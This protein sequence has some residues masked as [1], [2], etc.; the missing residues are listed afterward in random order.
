VSADHG[1]VDLL[2]PTEEEIRRHV[3]VELHARALAELVRPA[4]ASASDVRPTIEGHGDYVFGMLLGPVFVPGEDRKY[5]QEVDFVLTPDRLLTVR[6]TP[7][8]D[9]PFDPSEIHRVCA[10]RRHIK[11]GMIAYHFADAVAEQFL[12]L[13]D[14]LEDELEDV[15]SGL[16]TRPAPEVQRQFI[17]LRQH[18]IGIRRTLGPTR[19][20]MRSVV[21]GR[22][23]IEGKPVFRR[24]VFPLDVELHFAQVYDK[25]L[26]A[27][28]GLD[29]ARD[30]IT[31][32]RDFH[33]SLAANEQNRIGRMLTVIASLLLFPT[34]IVGVYGQ[35]F[36]H[37]PE[38]GWRYGYLFSWGVIV[39]VTLI[40]L[41]LFRWRRWI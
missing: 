17:E 23:D 31:S 12:D 1:W 26:R 18:V 28:E 6:K 4:A 38:L 20:A 36:H 14:V 19:D 39:A 40:Q 37:M 27:S 41:A 16:E 2:D 30:L 11:P 5:V 8:S 25:L 29:F 10:M 32:L 33:Q 13:I 35:N 24:E 3:T 9:P 22:A 21:D 7:G 34:F 15:E